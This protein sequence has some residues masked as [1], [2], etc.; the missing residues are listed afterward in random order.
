MVRDLTVGKYTFLPRAA[1][2][3]LPVQA[4]TVGD[5]AWAEHLITEPLL[6]DL[7]GLLEAIQEELNSRWNGQGNLGRNANSA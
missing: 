2:S 5:G 3:T 6:R 4:T 1:H 7:F